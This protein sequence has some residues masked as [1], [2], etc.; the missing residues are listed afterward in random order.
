MLLFIQGSHYVPF[1]ISGGIPAEI[2]NLS[3]LEELSIKNVSLY[4]DI[5]SSIFNMSSL[6]YLD[7]SDNNLLGNISTFYN[8]PKLEELYL[9]NNK[10][11][12]MY[13]KSYNIL[14]LSI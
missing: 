14:S 10:L 11:T 2:G 5:P 6:I 7:L 12:G 9:Y 4:G 1:V 8:L 13:I 3:K